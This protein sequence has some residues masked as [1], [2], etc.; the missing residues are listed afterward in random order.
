MNLNYKRV[1][2]RDL[3]NEAKL[4]KCMGILALWELD[5]VIP[6]LK[7]TCESETTEFQIALMDEGSLTLVNYHITIYNQFHTFKTTYNSKEPFP[8]YVE[9]KHGKEIEVMQLSGKSVIPTDEFLNYIHS[10]KPNI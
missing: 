7:I 6:E 9:G 10:L 4:L 8:L 1:I 3:F 5:K 2:P